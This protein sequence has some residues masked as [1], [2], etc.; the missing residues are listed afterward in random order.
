MFSFFFLP[1]LCVRTQMAWL[2]LVS[3]TIIFNDLMRQRVS[4]PT[5]VSWVAPVWDLFEGR[6]TDRATALWH[7]WILACFWLS[8][9][10]AVNSNFNLTITNIDS[11]PLQVT[12]THS[13]FY[14][15]LKTNNVTELLLCAF[16]CF[17]ASW[18]KFLSL[19]WLFEQEPGGLLDSHHDADLTD[20]S[21]LELD[22]YI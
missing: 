12:T 14:P 18:R 3:A 1:Y 22:Y 4:K 2:G 15:E 21:K 5:S 19:F 8:R 7:F 16:Q 17:K 9:N 6:S 11:I 20:I 10:W 13:K